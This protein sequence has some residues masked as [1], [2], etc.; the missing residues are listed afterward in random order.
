MKDPDKRKY[1]YLMLAV[2]GG[3]SASIVV[4]F[5]MYRFRGIGDLLK[6][7]SDILA[8]FI[9]G[10]VIAYLLRPL[11]NWYDELFTD[12]LPRKLRR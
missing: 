2:F 5:F 7:L 3:I 8:P 4:F 9:Y 12:C 1:L 10:G 11:C 6:K